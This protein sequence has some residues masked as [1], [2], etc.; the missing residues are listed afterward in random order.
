MTY[1]RFLLYINHAKNHHWMCL[2]RRGFR[3]CRFMNCSFHA[4]T[5]RERSKH[6]LKCPW[7]YYERKV[8]KDNRETFQL[9]TH[10]NDS[11]HRFNWPGPIKFQL[12]FQ[13]VADGKE[14]TMNNF[15]S[16]SGCQHHIITPMDLNVLGATYLF[17]VQSYQ[18]NRPA[19]I[20]FNLSGSSLYYAANV[21]RRSPSKLKSKL[22]L[23]QSNEE[24]IPLAMG[25][26]DSLLLSL[27]PVSH[28]D[29]DSKAFYVFMRKHDSIKTNSCNKMIICQTPKAGVLSKNPS[30]KP[31]DSTNMKPIKLKQKYWNE[32]SS[33]TTDTDDEGELVIIPRLKNLGNTCFANSVLQ[34]LF[35]ITRLCTAI[36]QHTCKTTIVES[37]RNLFF[38]MQ[39]HTHVIEPWDM[40]LGVLPKEMILGQQQDAHEY[41]SYLL[42]KL[43]HDKIDTIFHGTQCDNIHCKS[44]ECGAYDRN[45]SRINELSTLVV[46]PFKASFNG[47]LSVQQ[48]VND[49]AN[50]QLLS[51]V[52]CPRCKKPVY[53]TKKKSSLRHMF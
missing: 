21:R 13:K 41:L 27:L 14:Y 2:M 47:V 52:E 15:N 32:E 38:D 16:S 22:I 26:V 29:F 25:C 18:H 39:T 45:H 34:A 30:F 4:V 33:D 5:D 7:G 53:Q 49:A 44:S 51:D 31:K 37:L 24:A 9:I 28:P 8:M 6:Q 20:I 50:E 36:L 10:V 12:I 35:S 23:R 40:L 3:F 19:I 1:D 46:N 17:G 42:G 43:H 48:L 11:T